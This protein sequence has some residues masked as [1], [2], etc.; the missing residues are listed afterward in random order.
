MRFE[1][2]LT[3]PDGWA[4]TP[5]GMRR[6]S[7]FRTPPSDA[8]GSLEHELRRLGAVDPVTSSDLRVK[9]DGALYAGEVGARS[10]DPGVAVRW[11]DL[12][13]RAERVLACDR[14][15]RPYENARAIAL[16]I[17]ALR[18]LDRWGSTEV[19]ERAFAGFAA[20]PSPAES[21]PPWWDVLNVTPLTPLPV[22]EAAY[23]ALA[24]DAH[25]DRPGG[26]VERMRALSDAI[27]AAR[28]ARAEHR[29][30][31]P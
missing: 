27:A 5:A 17:E 13:A 21:S 23:R 3:W 28:A 1:F 24:R 11:R 16:T 22:A 8:F 29:V 6:S 31:S 25:P 19:V 30:S 15:E 10:S 2:P 4:R 7:A 12:A 9:V 18:G 20:L 26:S 14:W